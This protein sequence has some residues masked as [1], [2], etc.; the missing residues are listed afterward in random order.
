[1]Y[2]FTVT[3]LLNTCYMLGIMPGTGDTVIDNAIYHQNF[4]DS[5]AWYLLKRVLLD[6]LLDQIDQKARIK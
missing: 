6:N 4:G 3:L 1:M 2:L 5:K